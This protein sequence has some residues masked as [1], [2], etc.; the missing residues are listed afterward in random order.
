MLDEK[1]KKKSNFVGQ[2]LVQSASAKFDRNS[3]VVGK[4]WGSDGDEYEDGLL[5]RVNW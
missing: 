1:K 4:M 3:F 2:I 5:Y